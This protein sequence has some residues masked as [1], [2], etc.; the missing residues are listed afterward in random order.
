VVGRES[1]RFVAAG[2]QHVDAPPPRQSV[3]GFQPDRVAFF[4]GDLVE[5]CAVPG[6]AGRLEAAIAQ[7]M[8]PDATGQSER[9]E[10]RQEDVGMTPEVEQQDGE[11][12]GEV[13]PG[14]DRA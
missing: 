12:T 14:L 13:G 10:R 11:A 8:D 1:D 3:Q 6:E 7:K 9:A 4:L 5:R 2:E